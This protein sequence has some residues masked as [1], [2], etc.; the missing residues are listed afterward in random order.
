MIVGASL[1]GGLGDRFDK[2]K[3]MVAGMVLVGGALF[4]FGVVF[5]A[6]FYGF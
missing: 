6:T 3:T 2:I 1:F 5:A 4:I